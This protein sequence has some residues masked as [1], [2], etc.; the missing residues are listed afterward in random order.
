MPILSAKNKTLATWVKNYSK[1]YIKLF[2][3]CTFLLAFFTF[4]QIVAHSCGCQNS[5]WII[6]RE[7]ENKTETQTCN[8][9]CCN[10]PWPEIQEKI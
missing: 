4:G 10:L 9:S 3:T 5:R 1:I 7:D 8:I 6:I 2:R